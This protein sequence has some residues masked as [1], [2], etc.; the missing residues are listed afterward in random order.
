MA[1]GK[2]TKAATE[3]GKLA[4]VSKPGHVAAGRRSGP[5]REHGDAR[6]ERAP[7]AEVAPAH[8]AATKKPEGQARH[9]RQADA[10]R[11][12]RPSPRARVLRAWLGTGRGRPIPTRAR[13]G[14]GAGRARKGDD[15]RAAGTRNA[16]GG[17]RRAFLDGNDVALKPLRTRNPGKKPR[18][19]LFPAPRGNGNDKPRPFP[20]GR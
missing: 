3:S 8:L 17:V 4:A 12:H 2:G 11:R 10:G 20:F 15:G 7:Q 1:E 14:C 5:Q 16:R 19:R 9:C 18:K 13:S 6:G